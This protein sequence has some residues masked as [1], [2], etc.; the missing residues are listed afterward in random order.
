MR[1]WYPQL[2]VYDAIRRFSIIFA[3]LGDYISPERLFIADF[4]CPCRR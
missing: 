3:E 1:L 2:D 4:F